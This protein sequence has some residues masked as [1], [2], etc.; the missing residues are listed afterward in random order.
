MTLEFLKRGN[1]LLL[2]A[3]LS[4][5]GPW[6][7]TA[8]AQGDDPLTPE[9]RMQISEIQDLQTRQ[10]YTDALQKLDELEAAHPEVADI[11]N[12][13]GS[14]WLAG[15]LRDYDK[16]KEQFEKALQLRP[17]AMAALFNM[18][19][20]EFVVHHFDVAEKKFAALLADALK[21]P[22]PIRHLI[23]YKQAV[24][25]VKQGKISDAE[26]LVKKNF[27]FMDDTPAYYYTNAAVEFQKDNKPKAQ[28]WMARA[29]AIFGKQ[30]ITPYVDTL[31]EVRW[32]PHIG[33]PELKE[34]T[35]PAE[36]P[37]K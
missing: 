30:A 14:I 21:I 11:Y 2:V 28:E 25:M 24:C 12:I 22:L 20:L 37:A 18:A 36:A 5:V 33:L 13:R 8:Q 3:M 31:V 34:S 4:V 29:E 19:E 6:A 23:L 26:E 10:R 9:I 15:P 17:N 32:L 7:L 1:S 16:S 27:T 35:A